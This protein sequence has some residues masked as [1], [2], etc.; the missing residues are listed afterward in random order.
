M[1]IL[2]YF[3]ILI[4]SLILIV[5]VIVL[6]ARVVEGTVIVPN[7]YAVLK[8]VIVTVVAAINVVNGSGTIIS[9]GVIKGES[10]TL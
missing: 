6:T 3:G 9:D 10:F 7:I 1:S 2:I 4:T 8:G 5:S